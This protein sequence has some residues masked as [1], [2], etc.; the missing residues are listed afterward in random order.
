MNGES[1]PVRRLSGNYIAPRIAN[2][3]VYIG[4]AAA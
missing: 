1:R 2:G 3:V 4:R